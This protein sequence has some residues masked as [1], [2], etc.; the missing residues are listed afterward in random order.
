[1]LLE[2]E[3][4]SKYFKFWNVWLRALDFQFQGTGL[5]ANWGW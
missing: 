4:E 3:G 1:M 2:D 5:D